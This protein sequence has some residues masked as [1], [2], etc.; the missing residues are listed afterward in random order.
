MD[1]SSCSTAFSNSDGFTYDIAAALKRSTPLV[2][3]NSR[4]ADSTYGYPYVI[5]ATT[6]TVNTAVTSTDGNTCYSD[7]S[8]NATTVLPGTDYAD[9]LTNFGGPKC[10]SDYIGRRS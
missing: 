6:F 10:Y 9:E 4:P 3:T 8:G 2:G 1:K 7:G 5:L